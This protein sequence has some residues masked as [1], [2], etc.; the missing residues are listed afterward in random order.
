MLFH[1]LFAFAKVCICICVRVLTDLYSFYVK[2]SKV[3]DLNLLHQ[4]DYVFGI[5][6]H[7]KEVLNL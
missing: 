6:L 2:S 5:C 7:I 1:E 4:K 3:T